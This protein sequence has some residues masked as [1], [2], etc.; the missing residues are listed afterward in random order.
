MTPEEEHVYQVALRRIQEAEKNKSVE[1]DLSNLSDLTRF[2][3]ELA[4]LTSLQSLNLSGC[5]Q[6]SGDLAPLAG[7]TSL[8]SLNLSLCLLSGDLAPLAGLTSLQSLNLSRCE[9]L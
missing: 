6:L 7:L 9:Q 4:G 1:L 8:Q 3:S 2:P 5:E